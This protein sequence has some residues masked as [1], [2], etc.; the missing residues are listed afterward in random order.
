MKEIHE[1]YKSFGLATLPTKENK[2]TDVRGT[3]KGGVNEGYE[4]AHGIGIICGECSGGLECLDFDNHFGDAKETLSKFV[5]GKVKEIYEKYKLPIE[6]TLS[7]GYHFIYRADNIEGNLKLAE[8]LKN[9]KPDAIIETR[10]E[11]GYFVSAPTQGYKLIKNTFDNIAKITNEERDIIIH[12]ARSFNEVAKKKASVGVTGQ[13]RPGDRYNESIEALDDVKGALIRAGWT[14]PGKDSGI[15][16]TLGK[17]GP[18]IFYPFSSNSH[19]FEPQTGYTPFQVIG[20]LDYNGDFSTLAK[21]LASKYSDELS[22][23]VEKKP[24]ENTVSDLDRLLNGSYIDVSIP[25]ARPPVC[26]EIKDKEGYIVRERRLFT[27]GNFSA[28]TGKGKSKKTFLTSMLL[29]SACLKTPHQNKFIGRL[30]ENKSA[31]LLFDTEQSLYDAYMVTKRVNNLIGYQYEGFGSFALREYSPRERIAIIE[32][33][34]NKFKDNL[35]YVVIDGIADLATAIND[36][37]IASATVGLLMKWSKIYN[38]HITVIIHQNKNDEYATGHLGS[39][40]IKKAETVIKVSK[41]TTDPAASLVE[42]DLIRGVAEFAPFEFRIN[43]N[44]L[45]VIQNDDE[46]IQ[47]NP[48]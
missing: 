19:P 46:E 30:P 11:G 14:R 5:T 7:G 43:E 16:A 38:C 17:A 13:D 24:V 23:K 44:G 9:G 32:H 41:S 22:F 39:S 29:A 37:E 8:R 48:F 28:I 20:L 15:S 21:E 6:S 31:V 25:I 10:G 35:G 42:C 4:L 47:D 45:P 36:E 18:A 27:L 2:S 12:T 3:W 1:Q 40:I 34:L 33:A 26:I